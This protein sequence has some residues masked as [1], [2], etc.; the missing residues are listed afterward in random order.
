MNNLILLTHTIQMTTKPRFH[1]DSRNIPYTEQAESIQTPTH[2]LGD[3]G[4]L[5][6]IKKQDAEKFKPTDMVP[7]DYGANYSTI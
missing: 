6:P 5:I 1:I 4:E 2:V 3:K 7:M